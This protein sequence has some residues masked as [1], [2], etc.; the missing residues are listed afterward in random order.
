MSILVFLV[1]LSFLI[2]LFYARYLYSK[3]LCRLDNIEAAEIFD[4]NFW[5]ENK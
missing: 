5:G 2:S 1:I 4:S 3:V